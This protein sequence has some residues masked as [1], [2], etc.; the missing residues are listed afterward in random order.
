[1][2]LEYFPQQGAKLWNLL[3][4]DTAEA[5]NVNRF[6]WKIHGKQVHDY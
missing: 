1:M 3:P 6:K 4:Q 5:D 2:K